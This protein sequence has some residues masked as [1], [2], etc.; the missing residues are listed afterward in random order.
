MLHGYDETHKTSKHKVEV[1]I[2]IVQ[3]LAAIQRF[4]KHIRRNN[5]G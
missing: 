1:E 5:R 3:T 2:S 4:K